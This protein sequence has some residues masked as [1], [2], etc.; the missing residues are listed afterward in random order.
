MSFT[1]KI[2][3]FLSCQSLSPP[4]IT[5]SGMQCAMTKAELIA[6]GYPVCPLPPTGNV[7]VIIPIT[8]V[9]STSRS[10]LFFCNI[11]QAGGGNQAQGGLLLLS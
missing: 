10:R 2:V 5:T 3:L 11:A 8:P 6:G 7:T 9:N 1:I 4:C